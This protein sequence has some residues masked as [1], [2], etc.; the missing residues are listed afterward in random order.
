MVETLGDLREMMGWGAMLKAEKIA[1]ENRNI[2]GPFYIVMGAKADPHLRGSIVNGQYCSGGLQEHWVVTNLRP[3]KVLGILVWYV[4]HK[5]GVF[6]IVEE[7]S[8]PP[9]IPLDPSLLSDRSEDQCH[10]V[11]QTGKD[12]QVL[13]S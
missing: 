2:D 7:L 4:D 1:N 12:N 6:E 13:L 3:P 11:M 5:L 8:L 10:S 9:D